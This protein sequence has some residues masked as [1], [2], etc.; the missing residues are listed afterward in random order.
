[1]TCEICGKDKKQEAD[2]KIDDVEVHICQ[3]CWNSYYE[4][5]KK[6]KIDEIKEAIG[7]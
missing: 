6:I 2:G 1:M 3:D 5:K 4:S 7:V